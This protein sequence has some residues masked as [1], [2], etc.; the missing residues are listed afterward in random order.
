MCNTPPQ[1]CSVALKN[2]EKNDNKIYIY[3][4]KMISKKYKCSEC[5]YESEKKYNINRHMMAKH[6]KDKVN[7]SMNNNNNIHENNNVNENNVNE[8][9]NV[10]NDNK[11]S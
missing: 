5:E 6:K 10:H 9:N 11:C 7:I 3:L 2:E 1:Y 8:N 4:I